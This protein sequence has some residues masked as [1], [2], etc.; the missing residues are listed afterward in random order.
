VQ[1]KINFDLVKFLT[2]LKYPRYYILIFRINIYKDN[3]P[4]SNR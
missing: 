2:L 4:E 3:S 1:L